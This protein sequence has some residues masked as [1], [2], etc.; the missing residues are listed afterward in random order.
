MGEPATVHISNIA[1]STS[2]SD[3]TSFFSFCGKIINLTL[4]PGPNATSPKSASITFERQSAAKTAVLL[5]GTP[6]HNQPLEVTAA[7][8]LEDIAG[9][10]VTDNGNVGPNGEIPQEH[11]PRAAIFAE[12]LSHG[13]EIADA[14][15][16]RAIEVDKKQNITQRF[17]NILQN[18]YSTIDAKVH[19]TERAK[20]A[21]E[22]YHLTEKA[23]SGYNLLRRYFEKAVDAAPAPIRKFYE[24]SEKQVMEIHEEAKRLKELRQEKKRQS[25][26][27]GQSAD[28]KPFVGQ[29]QTTCQCGGNQ[30]ACPCRE[31][32][33][34]C[35]GCEK[36]GVKENLE[37]A[38]PS[39]Q[40]HHAMEDIKGT[41]QDVVG[42]KPPAY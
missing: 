14:T 40:F 23:N 15:L 19:A 36:A 28:G 2:E 12:Y 10:H 17:T 42:D 29:G 22:Q 41:A 39:G 35:A 16:Q 33:C 21:E 18:A 5:D 37:K 8:T 27:F 31:G 24:D 30:G 13:Y 6:L 1:P 3:L 26:T 20:A 9:S 4:T 25:Q 32:K 38:G 11:K 34:A 7:H